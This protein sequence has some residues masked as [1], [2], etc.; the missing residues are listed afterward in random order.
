MSYFDSAHNE[1]RQ[2]QWQNKGPNSI[3][4]G[5]ESKAESNGSSKV[6]LSSN[7]MQHHAFSTLQVNQ[8]IKQ[9]N[10][11][12]CV[13]I[14]CFQEKKKKKDECI[15]SVLTM[16]ELAFDTKYK[17]PEIT[18]QSYMEEKEEKEEKEE[19]QDRHAL[20]V[21][22]TPIRTCTSDGEYTKDWNGPVVTDA[23]HQSEK[24]P[25]E[26][27]AALLSVSKCISSAET[28]SLA[29][30][31][32][33]Y[34]QMALEQHHEKL[35]EK[36]VLETSWDV[37][38]AFAAV[39]CENGDVGNVDDAITIKHL[40]QL[41][42][43]NSDTSVSIKKAFLFLLVSFLCLNKDIQLLMR[44]LRG[45]SDKVDSNAFRGTFSPASESLV[46]KIVSVECDCEYGDQRGNVWGNTVKAKFISLLEEM[47][48]IE[49]VADFVRAAFAQRKISLSE[50]FGWIHKTTQEYIGVTELL[51]FMKLHGYQSSTE[52]SVLYLFRRYN[53]VGFAL[54]ALQKYIGQLSTKS[55]SP[56]DQT[57][58][59]QFYH[60]R[61]FHS[62]FVNELS[63]SQN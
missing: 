11:K 55:N 62:Q 47:L 17:F 46:K 61:I 2:R 59:A 18:V 39:R 53:N 20:P 16:D 27:M 4:D 8:S 25:P 52:Q 41:F 51:H 54:F 10:K 28:D 31:R 15:L 44:R 48:V 30:A 5:S 33:L 63:P 32:V 50:A 43:V 24:R 35:L 36:V 23:M 56:D 9:T 29:L 6:S 58:M 57:S 40:Q 19:E 12:E 14:N 38:R 21:G 37:T 22:I 3:D 45:S 13:Y 60:L 26:D 42:N 49:K 7:P 1:S 34:V